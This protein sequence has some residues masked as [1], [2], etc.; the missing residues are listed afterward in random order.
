MTITDPAGQA[1]LTALGGYLGLQ[2][3]LGR[4][5]GAGVMFPESTPDVAAALAQLQSHNVSLQA[6]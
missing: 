2:R 5:A 3:V 4:E 1:H 6:G